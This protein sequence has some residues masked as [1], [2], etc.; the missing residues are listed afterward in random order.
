MIKKY[1]LNVWL[2]YFD[3]DETFLTNSTDFTGKKTIATTRF[4][5]NPPSISAVI[6]KHYLDDGHTF[7]L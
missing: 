1:I 4:H 5:I 3:I 6:D 2:I 7:M